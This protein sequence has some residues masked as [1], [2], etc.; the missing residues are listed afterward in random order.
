M[1]FKAGKYYIGD[2]CYVIGD[3]NGWSW[4]DVLEQ[5]DYFRNFDGMI[6]NSNGDSFH[7]AGAPTRYGDGCYVDS[8]GSEY[9]VDAGCIACIPVSA[10]GLTFDYTGGHI[11]DIPVDFDFEVKYGIFGIRAIGWML[12]TTGDEYD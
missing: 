5:T 1:N 3:K 6:T 4:D 7:V 11:L 8:F 10:L 12:D 9:M 2:P